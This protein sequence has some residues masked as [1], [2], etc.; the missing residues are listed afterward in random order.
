[1]AGCL[2]G[3]VSTSLLG[4]AAGSLESSLTTILMESVLKLSSL[5]GTFYPMLRFWA[6]NVCHLLFCESYRVP[7]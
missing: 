1:M 2:A 4:L 7:F 5:T 6:C 3:S